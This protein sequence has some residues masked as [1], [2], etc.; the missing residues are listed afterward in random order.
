MICLVTKVLLV[1]L[2]GLKTASFLHSM[3][4][5]RVD[6]A[7][8]SQEHD[9]DAADLLGWVPVTDTRLSYLKMF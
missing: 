9:S 6:G 4:E 2:S 7:N 5:E 8:F 1:H 3:L